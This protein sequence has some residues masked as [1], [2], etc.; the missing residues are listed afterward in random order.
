MLQK[1][2][3]IPTIRGS[4]NPSPPETTETERPPDPFL[5]PPTCPDAVMSSRSASQGTS[6]PSS[7]R[8]IPDVVYRSLETSLTLQGRRRHGV[9][10]AL[11]R[12]DPAS[13][14]QPMQIRVGDEDQLQMAAR[15]RVSHVGNN[16]YD[17]RCTVEEGPSR[18]FTYSL[19]ERAGTVL[20]RAPCLGRKLG[21]FLLDELEREIGRRH[22]RSQ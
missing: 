15:I 3:G 12:V 6:I 7:V 4:C 16:V 1:S 9:D 10:A 11:E 17:V 14:D 8:R 21:T 13:T 19:P 2:D 18:R 22:L 20:S 5:L